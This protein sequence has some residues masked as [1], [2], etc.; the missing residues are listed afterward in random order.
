MLLNVQSSKEFI[1]CILGLE[2]HQCLR[3][4][5]SYCGNGR[6]QETKPMMENGLRSCSEVVCCVN[7][8]LRELGR[9]LKEHVYRLD[10]PDLIVRGL[11]LTLTFLKI[12]FDGSLRQENKAGAVASSRC[13]HSFG[14]F[15]PFVLETHPLVQQTAVLYLQPSSFRTINMFV[16]MSRLK[17]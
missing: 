16:V 11:H 15:R 9:S 13:L 12:D 10:H 7:S 6:M 1:C 17:Y 5:A 4:C 3:V 8:M 2:S 14:R